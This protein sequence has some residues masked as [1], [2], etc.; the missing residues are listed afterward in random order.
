MSWWLG[1]SDRVTN[2]CFPSPTGL[3]KNETV[4]PFSFPSLALLSPAD[5]R[6][7]VRDPGRNRK[8]SI[9]TLVWGLKKT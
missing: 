4:A 8:S 1:L 6:N 2:A 9:Y 3:E 5:I 7:S